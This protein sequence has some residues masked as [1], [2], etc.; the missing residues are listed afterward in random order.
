MKKYC[1]VDIE[2]WSAAGIETCFAENRSRP[3]EALEMKLLA[4][5]DL[6]ICLYQ[7]KEVA[8][9]TNGQLVS[10]NIDPGDWPHRPCV[11]HTIFSYQ[12][13]LPKLATIDYRES[14]TRPI[15]DQRDPLSY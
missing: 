11:P 12:I 6:H 9:L 10:S 3:T 13:R 7:S 4:P 14:A 5:P 8:C 15:T 1:V 2:N